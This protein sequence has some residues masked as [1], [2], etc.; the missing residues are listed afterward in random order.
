MNS[1]QLKMKEVRN[2]AKIMFNNRVRKSVN[3]ITFYAQMLFKLLLREL[4]KFNFFK[5]LK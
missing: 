5:W 4:F 2:F 1:S 3:D